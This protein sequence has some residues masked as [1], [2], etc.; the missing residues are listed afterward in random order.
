MK[1]IMKVLPIQYNAIQLNVL[2]PSLQKRGPLCTTI[3][4]NIWITVE[5]KAHTITASYI[6]CNLIFRFA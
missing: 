5:E 2:V 6:L 1:I 4:V 3:S